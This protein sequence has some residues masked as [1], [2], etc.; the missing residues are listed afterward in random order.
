MRGYNSSAFLSNSFWVAMLDGVSEEVDGNHMPDGDDPEVDIRNASG[1]SQ[2]NKEPTEEDNRR[3]F[4]QP[5][6]QGIFASIFN[7]AFLK[8][9]YSCISIHAP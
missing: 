1:N 9:I 3:S 4:L 6:R 5:V 7:T 8:G 2:T